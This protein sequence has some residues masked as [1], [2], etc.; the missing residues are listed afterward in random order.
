[1]E[2]E[3]WLKVE[4]LYHAARERAASERAHFLAEACAGDDSLRQEVESLLTQGEG[5]GSFM[6]TPA[7][8][9]AAQTLARDQARVQA[10][11][12][13]SPDGMLGRTVSHY[14]ILEKL[15]GGMGVVYKAQDTRLGRAVALRFLA[16][17]APGLT[18]CGKTRLLLFSTSRAD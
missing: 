16:K 8:D 1:V 12:A 7:L 4:R 15:G 6:D 13:V 11:N 2:R 3:S 5:T 14:R 18:G 9:L 17:V 10:G